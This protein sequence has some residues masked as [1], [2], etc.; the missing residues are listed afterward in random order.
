MTQREAPRMPWFKWW[1]GTAADMKFRMLAEKVSIPVA[2]ILGIWSYMLEQASRHPERGTVADIDLGLMSYTLQMSEADI[3]TVRNG[4]KR[5]GLVT[6]TGDIAK[7]EDRQ[8]KREKSEPAG[9]S[10][11]RV[12]RYREKQKAM[13]NNGL[14][15]GN[16]DVT[17]ETDETAGNGTKRPKRKIRGREEEEVETM[18]KPA[19]SDAPID[20]EHV[21][22]RAKRR[23]SE[24]DYENARWLFDC[25]KAVNPEAKKPN[26]DTWA[27]DI[28]LMREIDNRTHRDIAALFRFAKKDAFWSPNIQSPGKLREKWDQLTE[29]RARPGRIE[30]PRLNKQEQ[31]EEDNRAVVARM[32]EEQGS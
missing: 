15:G 17:D 27:D 5:Y 12:Q 29:L 18:S 10:T 28:R 19:A 4:M 16:A 14:D 7:W 30:A 6:E 24:E 26:F 23:P 32:M 20:A 21:E 25:Q 11:D 9:A 31:L 22:K 3:E 1:D 2:S 8:A 13:K